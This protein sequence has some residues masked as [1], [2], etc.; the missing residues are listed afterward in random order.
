MM[1]PVMG[2][3]GQAQLESGAV[4]ADGFVPGGGARVG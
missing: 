4:Q 1:E 2:G 3:G